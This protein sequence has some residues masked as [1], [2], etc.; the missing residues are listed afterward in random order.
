MLVHELMNNGAKDACA[1]IYKDQHITY[2]EFQEMTGIYRDYLYL[3]GIRP[4]ENV[5]LLVKNSP[6]FVY[7]YMAIISL[8]AVVVPININLVQREIAYI[9]EDAG[10]KNFITYQH[11]DLPEVV[12]QLMILEFAPELKGMSL[13]PA[14]VSESYTGDRECVII[15][16]SGTTGFPK[17]AV[18][19]HTNLVSNATAVVKAV[20]IT[21]ADNNLCVLPMFHSFAWTVTVLAPLVCGAAVTIME[22]F[23]PK[24]VINGIS[25]YQVTIISGVPSM[26]NYYLALGVPEDFES[27]RIFLSG[28][29]PLPVEILNQFHQ[30]IGK[31]IT[32]GY[33]LSEASPV[34]ALNP[35]GR[36]KP[37]S[38]GPQLPGVEVKIFDNEG[39]ELTAGEV[40]ELV[41]K[42]PNVMKGY[43]NMPEATAKALVNGWLHTGDLAYK[44]QEDYIFIVDRL[45]DI[46]IVGGLNVYP[47]EI[48]EVLYQ[49]EGIL[50]AAV[51]GIPDKLRI[52]AVGAF[53]VI[54]E[55]GEFN[56]R[57]ILAFLNKSLANYKLPREIFVVDALPKNSTGKIDK[58][59]LRELYAQRHQK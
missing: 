29:A 10:I 14:P 19:T 24:D 48:E 56:K 46:I 34:C 21:S 2:G 47:R 28:G 33:G 41:V 11:V 3:K 27:V 5:G 12:Q 6:E 23:F 58:K 54:K 37:G 1:F 51:I 39:G 45:K 49:Y 30:K 59:I 22:V 55:G 38:I 18:L 4:G 20:G 50:E 53:V 25:R 17:G 52:E 32:E 35:I 31:P 36:G 8:G 7:S 57:A 26:Y 9:V 16:T 13:A 42:G 40:G 43:F 15:Y 44:D